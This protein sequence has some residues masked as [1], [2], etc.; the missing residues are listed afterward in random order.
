MKSSMGFYDFKK[1]VLEKGGIWAT[2]NVYFTQFR[3][4]YVAHY[5]P[6]F[7]YHT[8]DLDCSIIYD[9]LHDKWEYVTPE[10][11]D[12]EYRLIVPTLQAMKGE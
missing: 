9:W 5:E 10:S 12:A 11:Y 3:D 6:N 1:S 7:P 4:G 8:P 2:E